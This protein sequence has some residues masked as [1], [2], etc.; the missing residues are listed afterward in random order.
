MYT[1][2][3]IRIAHACICIS[4]HTFHHP[5]YFP[6]SSHCISGFQHPVVLQPPLP[7][8]RFRLRHLEYLGP[9]SIPVSLHVS[10]LS[11]LHQ[12]IAKSSQRSSSTI[13]ESAPDTPIVAHRTPLRFPYLPNHESPRVAIS[14]HCRAHFIYPT[15]LFNVSYFLIPPV[16]H[17]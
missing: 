15:T 1:A 5:S 12:D 13:F 7:H 6:S 4:C 11:M 3:S 9:G 17:T 8:I 16:I 10:P 14:W 2:R